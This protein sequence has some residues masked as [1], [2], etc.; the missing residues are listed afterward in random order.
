MTREYSKLEQGRQQEASVGIGYQGLGKE[1]LG[2][3]RKMSV[4]NFYLIGSIIEAHFE[5]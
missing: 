4:T 1:T 2:V 5:V 3:I